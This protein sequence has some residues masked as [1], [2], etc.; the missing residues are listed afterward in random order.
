VSFVIFVVDNSNQYLIADTYEMPPQKHEK[1][2]GIKKD[3]DQENA[4]KISV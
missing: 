1:H 2:K 4:E 3:I